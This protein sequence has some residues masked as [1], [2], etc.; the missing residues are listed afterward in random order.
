LIVGRTFGADVVWTPSIC[1]RTTLRSILAG[2]AQRLGV[3]AF[4]ERVVG[5]SVVALAPPILI[6]EV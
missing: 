1:G 2:V 3:P 4:D 5:C 6:G